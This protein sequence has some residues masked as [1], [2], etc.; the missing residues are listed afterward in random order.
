MSIDI[1]I[2]LNTLFIN[3]CIILLGSVQADIIERLA[4]KKIS[5]CNAY[6][7]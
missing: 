3:D 2:E 7:R 4:D 5:P 6:V 1:S